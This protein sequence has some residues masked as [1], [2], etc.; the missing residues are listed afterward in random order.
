MLDIAKNCIVMQLFPANVGT[1]GG[2]LHAYT[3]HPTFGP[4]SLATRLVDR[5]RAFCWRCKYT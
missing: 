5:Y 4:R 3:S 1:K 2:N